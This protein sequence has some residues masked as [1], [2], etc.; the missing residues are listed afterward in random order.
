MKNIKSLEIFLFESQSRGSEITEEQFF[1]YLKGD[2]SNYS[3]HNDL[4][5]R[6]SSNKEEFMYMDPTKFNRISANTTN[7]YTLLFDNLPSWKKYPKRSKSVIC[8]SSYEYANLYS[9][10]TGGNVHIVIPANNAV[11][12]IVPD[13][14]IWAGFTFKSDTFLTLKDFN[15]FIRQLLD[16]KNSIDWK[17][18]KSKL[19]DIT[20]ENITSMS[21]Y[22]GFEKE[23]ENFIKSKKSNFLEWLDKDLL[24]PINSGFI[25]KQYTKGFKYGSN[26]EIWTEGPI[27]MIEFNKWYELKDK[28]MKL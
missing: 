14:D 10:K 9:V 19:E 3:L 8:T 1:K 5:F 27:L 6:G 18:L 15:L 17:T 21:I 16:I 12:G 20:P 2:F 11:V 13:R 28:L 24:K 4:L 25:T 22:P 23:V 7:E 26:N